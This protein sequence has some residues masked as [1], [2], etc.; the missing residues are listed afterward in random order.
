MKKDDDAPDQSKSSGSSTLLASAKG[1]FNLPDDDLQKEATDQWNFT[2]NSPL[3][4]VKY[5]HPCLYASSK[6]L[7][8]REEVYEKV[9]Q[10][11]L[12]PGD[13][14]EPSN[15]YRYRHIVV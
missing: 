3:D 9:I 2:D 13:S 14:S 7:F 5:R 8:G 15:E 10:I 1:H 11:L 12:Q 6:N 4:F